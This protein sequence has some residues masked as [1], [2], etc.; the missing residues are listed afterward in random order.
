MCLDFGSKTIWPGREYEEDI[1]DIVE[2]LG[3]GFL[4]IH[5][6]SHSSMQTPHQAPGT[7]TTP[8]PVWLGNLEC[9]Y[10]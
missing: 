3:V 7:V 10:P 5:S 6:P 2:G 8:C 1:R 4:G 9:Q